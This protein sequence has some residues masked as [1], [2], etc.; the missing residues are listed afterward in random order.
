M[1]LLLAFVISCLLP[2]TAFAACEGRDL[3]L[4]L[5]AGDRAAL[6][7]ELAEIP[8]AE[9]NHWIARKD[10]TTLHLVGTLHTSD[11]RMD[12]IVGR[13][14][15]ALSQADAFW[16][17][18]KKTDMEAFEQGLATD[19]S[20]VLITSGPTLIDL[21]DD[22][23]WAALSNRLAERGIA[24]WMA[25]KMKPWFLSMM[26]GIP[27][28]IVKTPGADRGMDQRLTEL[29]EAH[30]IPQHSLEQVSDLIA[31]FESHPIEE[32]A[33]SIVRMADAFE[34]GDD[35]MVTMANAYMEERHAEILLVARLL[36]QETSEIAQDEFDKEWATF[37]DQLVVQRNRNWLTHILGIQGQTAVIAVGA[38]HLAGEEGLLHQLEQA[39]YDLQRAEF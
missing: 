30:D 18:V 23:S 31:I 34:A 36:G 19:F 4:D 1:R 10:G 16:F 11:P 17:E 5:T 21:L 33:Q 3:R 37:E 7:A 25:A 38:G 22:E 2:A 24:S 29:A 26:L 15:P 39:G 6:D 20:P 27:P 28:C 13:L 12:A 32:Q 35:H 9:G 8:F 14:T